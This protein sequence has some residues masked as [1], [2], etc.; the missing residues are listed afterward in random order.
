MTPPPP[1]VQT[2]TSRAGLG[3]ILVAFVVCWRGRHDRAR[4]IAGAG[5]VLGAGA[6]AG[7]SFWQHHFVLLTVAGAGLWRL[8]AARPRRTQA[9]VW[10]LALAPLIATVTLPFFVALVT[11]VETGTYRA[12]RE[13]GA[14]TAAVLV[15]LGVVTATALRSRRAETRP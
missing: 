2:A 11:G 14:P 9:V 8:L 1:L 4:R 12:L 10:T 13:W 6:L 15:F 3:G 7:P 5:L